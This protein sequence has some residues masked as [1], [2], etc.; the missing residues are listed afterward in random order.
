MGAGRGRRPSHRQ[1]DR[2][3]VRVLLEP[4]YWS[5]TGARVS[6]GTW[7]LLGPAHKLLKR[8]A[9]IGTPHTYAASYSWGMSA[10]AAKRYMR[11]TNV[12]LDPATPHAELFPQLLA[13]AACSERLGLIYL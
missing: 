3:F 1:R 7:A 6:A 2:T 9:D 4:P 11:L 13:R 12:S 10:S 5:A 8:L